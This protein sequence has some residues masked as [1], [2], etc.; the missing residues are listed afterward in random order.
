MF[1]GGLEKFSATN[2]LRSMRQLPR[3][4]VRTSWTPDPLF[5]ND[6]VD[7]L[8]LTAESE[9][10]ACSRHR[11]EGQGD[12]E[13]DKPCPQID[14]QRVLAVRLGASDEPSWRWAPFPFQSPFR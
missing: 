11:R 12:L 5:S 14:Q 10:K 3:W 2:F 9:N 1:K 4:A 13:V 8:H 7:R 6:G